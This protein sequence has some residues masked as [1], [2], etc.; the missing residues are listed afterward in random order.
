M[1]AAL[2]VGTP[3][4][5]EQRCALG[6]S[7]VA[8]R[9]TPPKAPR[10]PTHCPAPPP[11]HHASNPHLPRTCRVLDA[12]GY[13]PA[14]AA[15]AYTLPGTA[16]PDPAALGG[17]LGK[18]LSQWMRRVA[19]T[20]AHRHELAAAAAQKKAAAAAGGRRLLG[21]VE[22]AVEEEGDGEAA[23][24]VAA[25]AVGEDDEEEAE[26]WAQ[27]EEAEQWAQEE[28][29]QQQQQ[30]QEA[31]VGGEGQ[32]HNSAAAKAAAAAG[33][34]ERPELPPAGT[35]TAAMLAAFDDAGSRAAHT[36]A[37]RAKKEVMHHNAEVAAKV[38]RETAA[39][40]AA[41]GRA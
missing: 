4:L 35:Y 36:A 12:Y 23:E 1:A 33:G 30:Q 20:L 29:E 37:W 13:V 22:A 15:F 32:R 6:Q 17:G 10:L 14:D 26:Q 16:T 28:E 19:A 21:E 18:E 3:V 27:E 2:Q 25:E 7:L 41:R 24:A 31:G 8:H 34:G 5:T 11:Q 38:L 9:H 40:A 39:L